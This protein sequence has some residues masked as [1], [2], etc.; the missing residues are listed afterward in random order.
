MHAI[1]HF[2]KEK[3]APTSQ[4]RCRRGVEHYCFTVWLITSHRQKTKGAA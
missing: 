3:K 2:Y 1:Y 4:M